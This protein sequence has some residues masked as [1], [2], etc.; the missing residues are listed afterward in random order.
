MGSPNWTLSKRKQKRNMALWK[1]LNSIR[2]NRSNTITS[3][4]TRISKARDE[5]AT[6]GETVFDSELVKVALKGCIKHWTTFVDVIIAR[7]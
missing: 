4:L 7:Q 2:M 3:H 1:K 5:L 6:V